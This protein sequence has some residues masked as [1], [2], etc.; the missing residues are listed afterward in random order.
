MRETLALTFV[1]LLLSSACAS[2]QA[3]IA[4]PDSAPH[5]APAPSPP[6]EL[7]ATETPPIPARG[8]ANLD[9]LSAAPR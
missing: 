7:G 9:H 6:A 2:T 8:P 5:H 1:A 3:G 4:Q